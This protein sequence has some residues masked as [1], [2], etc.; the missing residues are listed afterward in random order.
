MKDKVR[1]VSMANT[2][3]ATI[4]EVVGVGARIV[5]Y[6]VRLRKRPDIQ[7]WGREIQILIPSEN[8][9]LLGEK[10]IITP[11]KSPDRSTGF[12]ILNALSVKGKPSQGETNDGKAP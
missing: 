11:V 5:E 2:S 12:G 8:R 6:P 7:V 10:L 4:G 1:V 9:F 3:A